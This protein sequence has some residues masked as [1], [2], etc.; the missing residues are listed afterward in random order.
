VVEARMASST[1]YPDLNSQISNNESL[2]DDA[3]LGYRLVIPEENPLTK[4]FDGYL[5]GKVTVIVERSWTTAG[6]EYTLRAAMDGETA[7]MA[8]W[9]ITTS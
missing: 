9:I 5:D 4:L 3:N 7:R 2:R 1:M 8:G 6:E